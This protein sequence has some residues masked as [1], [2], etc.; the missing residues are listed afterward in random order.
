MSERI[1]LH[2]LPNGLRVVYQ[3]Q[4]QTQIVNV[5]VMILAGSRD[6]SATENGIAHYIEHCVFKGAGKRKPHQVLK[7]LDSV[8]G[9]L[10]A[11]TTREKT[12]YYGTVHKTHTSRA[13]ELLADLVFNP[14]LPEKELEKEKQ[15][16]VDEI[17][18]YDD[19]PDESIYDELYLN[20]FPNQAM[21]KNILGTKETVASFSRSDVINFMNKH[22]V[23]HNMVVSIAG[24]LSPESVFQKVE[25]CFN[26][27]KSPITYSRNQLK[28]EQGFNLSLEK[29]FSQHHS[30][31]SYKAP[32]RLASEKYVM[33][34]MNNILGGA[35]LSAKLIMTIR[36][37]HGLSYQISTAYNAYEELGEF[38]IYY[39]CD[40]KN[41]EKA[42]NLV[43]K[44]LKKMAT[45][46]LTDRAL[47]LAKKQMIGQ[48][49]ISSENG[50]NLV[51]NNA[52]SVLNYNRVLSLK[53]YIQ[54][55][56]I[57]SSSAL[58]QLAQSMF[59]DQK[60]STVAYE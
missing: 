59:L 39:S 40:A 20:L 19:T 45:I 7:R 9:E 16:I 51:Q 29:D 2:T 48:A 8:G 34:L 47:S 15:V 54:S 46:P 11:F 27:N 43:N 44:E 35:G 21:G 30:I 4:K 37:K 13:L 33:Y 55:I 12:C 26:I 56:N 53:D 14:L 18:M 3:Q 31:I 22:Y 1:F 5:G 42:M 28:I 23:P 10:N 32:K 52:R 36:E 17:D 60:A 6:E 58:L 41:K 24:N 50:I 49:I 57:V 38:N 25:T